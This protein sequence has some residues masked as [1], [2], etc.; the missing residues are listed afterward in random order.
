M[1]K[2]IIAICFVL[3]SVSA[4]SNGLAGILK[5]VNPNL[6]VSRAKILSR[7]IIKY[8][9]EFN[10]PSIDIIS[11]GIVETHLKNFN[12]DNGKSIGYFQL[13]VGTCND[14]YRWYKN[15]YN[16]PKI[17]NDKELLNSVKAQVLYTTLNLAH[18]KKRTKNNKSMFLAYNAGLWG[19]LSGKYTTAYYVK[20]KKAK[21]MVY[22]LSYIIETED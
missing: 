9:K 8:S 21:N 5:E 19:Y 22:K 13:R 15:K 17:R 20:I 11:L 1:K 4:M 16:L 2:T 6:S 7:Y 18:L 10:V 12:G 14:L 3:T